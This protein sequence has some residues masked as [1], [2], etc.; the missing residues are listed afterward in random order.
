ML[1]RP[2][3]S[4]GDSDQESADGGS[5]TPTLRKFCD[6]QVEAEHAEERLTVIAD[7]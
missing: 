3:P 2:N 1:D 7:D 6:G 4:D 5:G